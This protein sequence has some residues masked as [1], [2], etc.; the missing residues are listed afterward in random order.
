[1]I[2]KK[3]FVE[4]SEDECRLIV[5]DRFLLVNF[6]VKKAIKFHLYYE[7]I[8][9]KQ[10][11][12]LSTEIQNLIEFSN[13]EL[14]AFEEKEAFEKSLIV[15]YSLLKK[16]NIIMISDIGLSNESIKNFKI[17]MEKVMEILD[18]KSLYF[19]RKKYEFISDDEWFT[20]IG[21]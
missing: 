17:I 20:R 10:I 2:I 5:D 8:K 11:E 21:N 9:N 7:K 18:N 6:P 19:V 13:D 12:S 16:H 4:I 14:L 15:I 3:G 1:M